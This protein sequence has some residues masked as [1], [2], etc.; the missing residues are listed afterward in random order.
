MTNKENGPSRRRVVGG[1]GAGLTAAGFGG[2]RASAKGEQAVRD[3]KNP[4]TEYPRPHFPS[5]S[6]RGPDL[7]AR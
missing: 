5:S 1:I 6:S 3:L 7:Q 2:Q 4:V